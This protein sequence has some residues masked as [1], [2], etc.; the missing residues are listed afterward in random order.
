MSCHL[1][2]YE[3][4]KPKFDV[5]FLVQHYTKNH[6]EIIASSIRL[7]NAIE[8]RTP[9]PPS[10]LF[11]ENPILFY[12]TENNSAWFDDVPAMSWFSLLAW[13]SPLDNFHEKMID[14][15]IP[16]NPSYKI[17]KKYW[18]YIPCQKYSGKKKRFLHIEKI[19][20]IQIK[21][22]WSPWLQGGVY[23]KEFIYKKDFKKY[24]RK[25]FLEYYPDDYHWYMN[26]FVEGKTII[27]SG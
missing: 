21:E 6:Q 1:S 20:F 19:P 25:Y 27:I 8:K 18:V 26:N 13:Y 12:T 22:L 4:I 2:L 9:N 11:R 3:V 17:F 14:Y 24:Y 7:I 10:W 16:C 15:L 5:D 23:D